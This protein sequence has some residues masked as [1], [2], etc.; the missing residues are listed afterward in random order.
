M[1]QYCEQ[2]FPLEMVCRA[3]HFTLSENSP[4]VYGNLSVV[5]DG[6]RY[7][8][9][10]PFRYLRDYQVYPFE[11]DGGRNRLKKGDEIKAHH[12][13]LDLLG[14]CLYIS[15]TVGG[16]EC[17][18]KVLKNEITC[19]VP[20][21]LVI[22]SEGAPVQVCVRVRSVCA[23]ACEVCAKGRD[24]DL[25]SVVMLCS[26]QVCVD[27]SWAVLLCSPHVCVDRSWSVL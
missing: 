25:V 9:P 8:S 10:Q 14:R 27:G 20:K 18:P 6:V 24:V 15:M 13:Y 22:P 21:D 1:S 17:H 3:P 16:R 7:S 12:K 26:P 11:Q 5:L 2:V 23:C 19:R 4:F